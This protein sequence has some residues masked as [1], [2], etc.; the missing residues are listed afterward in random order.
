MSRWA[1]APVFIQAMFDLMFA[2]PFQVSIHR[3]LIV[4][5]CFVAAFVLQGDLA[6]GQEVA[7]K[8][9]TELQ[10]RLVR[11]DDGAVEVRV[12]DDLWTRYI[13]DSQGRP[14]WYPVLGPGGESMTRGFPF[15]KAN[16]DEK[17]DHDHH[18]SLWLTHGEV[19]DIDFWIDDPGTGRIVDTGHRLSSG[20][21][22]AKF[23][24]DYRWE[25]AEGEKVMMERRVL[26]F[27]VQNGRRII[28]LDSKLTAE[29]GP[30]HIGDTKE[31]TFGIRV[32]GTMK[33]DAKKGGKI[34][35]AEGILDK[36]A[37]GKQ[38]AWVDYNGPV[39]AKDATDEKDLILA[40]IRIHQHPS[41]FGFPCRWH[42]RTYGLFAANPF[43]VYHF[44]GGE[45][46]DGV[47]LKKG[48]SL[49]MRFRTVFYR[50]PLDIKQ[51]KQDQS[52]YA[53]VGQD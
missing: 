39:A 4:P 24:A 11:T 2:N 51:A 15:Q 12:G 20:K 33:V 26:R 5:A 21:D 9:K 53:G 7:G 45:K 27:F 14:V 13:P 48:E 40:G 35:N 1:P 28:D 25:S 43:G 38:S 19:N 23:E 47:R 16:P 17:S 46:T 8:T 3:L 36:Q 31:G 42:V 50:G 52:Q 6:G 29:F 37:W 32:P 41:S 10:P 22:G 30:V 18:R 49:Q 44:T 34:T